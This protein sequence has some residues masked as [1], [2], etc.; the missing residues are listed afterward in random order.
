MRRKPLTIEAVGRVKDDGDFNNA[1]HRATS[2]NGGSVWAQQVAVSPLGRSIVTPSPSRNVASPQKL[3]HR[4][5]TR[6]QATTTR[7]EHPTTT[8]PRGHVVAPASA[9]PSVHLKAK[10]SPLR[11]RLG[12]Y[13][14]LGPPN[15]GFAWAV[16]TR[17]S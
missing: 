3:S 9:V 17:G 14:A 7:Q 1:L 5:S 2:L 15:R 12:R 11:L 8:P 16:P 6:G 13:H 4:C 10:L